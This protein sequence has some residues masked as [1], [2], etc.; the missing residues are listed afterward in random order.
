MVG[1]VQGVS[2]KKG[3]GS[4]RA[5]AGTSF[6]EGGIKRIM[7]TLYLMSGEDS[8]RTRM[9]RRGNDEYDE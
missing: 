4:W 9:R 2:E 1:N 8:E 6:G 7:Y 5:V 3:L